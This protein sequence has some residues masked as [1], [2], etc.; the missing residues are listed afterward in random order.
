[1]TVMISLTF[2]TLAVS[3][4]TTRFNIKKFYMVFALRRVFCLVIRTEGDF[5]FINH[6]LISFYNRGAKCLQRGTDWV[7][8]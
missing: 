2:Q 5:C 8:K 4:C 3:L 6:L 7:F 1:M